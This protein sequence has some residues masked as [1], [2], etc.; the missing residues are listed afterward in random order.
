V[1]FEGRTAL[2]TGGAGAIGLATAR[3]L[4]AEGARVAI[5]DRD[6]NRAEAAAATLPRAGDHAAAIGL[7]LDVTDERQLTDGVARVKSALGPVDVVV[8]AHGVLAT[9][10]ATE[11]TVAD[12]QRT[13]DV[14]LTGTFLT[15]RAVLPGMVARGRGSIVLL[16]STAGVVAEAGIA[17]YCASKGGVLMLGRQLAVDY[18]RKGVRVNVLCPGWIDTPFNDPAIEQGG[19]RAALE[20]FI[21]AMVP[22]GRQGTPDE[23][24]DVIAFLASDDARYVTGSVLLAD[25]GLTSL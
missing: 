1:R 14:N 20:P 10:S 2:I 4:A 24:A 11:T 3:R 7:R 5:A 23:I 8:C 25:G 9:G 22:L 18:A 6:G 21:D 12:W 15:A 16:S 17:A 19:G 13:L